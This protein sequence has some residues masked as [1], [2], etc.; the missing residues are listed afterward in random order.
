MLERRAA[1]HRAL[2]RRKGINT[3]L[4]RLSEIQHQVLQLG[5]NNPG[6]QSCRKGPGRPG[7]QAEGK[8]LLQRCP[9]ESKLSPAQHLGGHI[10]TQ[11]QFQGPHNT[12]EMP[13]NWRHPEEQGHMTAKERWRELGLLSL[14]KEKTQEES[15]G[16]FPLP[17][18]WWGQEQD[19]ARPFSKVHSKTQK[20]GIFSSVQQ[21]EFLSEIRRKDFMKNDH[22]PEQK[23]RDAVV[24]S[25]LRNF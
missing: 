8:P 12:R 19:G 15:N 13:T 7:E 22:I 24:I 16:S 6:Q 11:I 2:P 23:P 20:Q 17:K 1:I 4:V 14:E 9:A 5:W 10:W 18:E 3:N 25:I 21:G